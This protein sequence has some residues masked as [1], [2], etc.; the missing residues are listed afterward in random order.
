MSLCYDFEKWL[1]ITLASVAISLIVGLLMQYAHGQNMTIGQSMI[2]SKAQLLQQKQSLEPLINYC[3][4]HADRP[5]PIQ[6][7]ID[8]GFL[9]P[10]FRA[11]TCLSL[12]QTYDLIASNL[13][14]QQA[15]EEEQ[16]AKLDK[17]QQDKQARYA[18]CARNETKT[19][20]ECRTILNG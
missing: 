4:Q 18:Q 14:I 7:L 1:M 15:K 17:E 13:A 6:D 3:Y 10:E 5:N 8:K 9:S 2:L 12:K 20:D 16:Q 19:R 11:E